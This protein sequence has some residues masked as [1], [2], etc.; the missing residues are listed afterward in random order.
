NR[1]GP[2]PDNL[3]PLPKKNI[4]TGMGLDR[5]AAVLQGVESNFENDI[6]KPLCLAAGEVVG[7]KYDF[8]APHGRAL[9]RIADHARAVTF[10]IHE[11]VVPGNEKQGYV[12]RQLLRR[13]VLE[14]YLLG[15]QE[16]FLH[17]LV[18]P[19][20]R[21]MGRPYPELGDTVGRVEL[22]V[23]AEEEYFLRTV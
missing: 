12:V 1:V 20:A 8:T 3:R 7:R 9:R 10:C 18:A 21:V 15:R 22:V 13:A 16:P 2:P 19:V 23:K 5:T 17:Q 6:L 14:G 11:N 4:D